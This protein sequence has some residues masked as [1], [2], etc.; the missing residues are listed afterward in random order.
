MEDF[1]EKLIENGFVFAG[2]PVVVILVFFVHEFA[3][4]MAARLTGMQVETVSVGVGK[5]YFEKTDRLGTRWVIRTFPLKAHVHISDYHPEKGESYLKRLTVVLAG[6]VSNFILPLLLFFTFFVFWGRPSVPTIVTGLEL[7]MPAYEAGI[8]I[9]DKILAIDN[10]PVSNMDEVKE[11][12]EL[13]PTKPLAFM[14]LREGQQLIFDVTPQWH[15]YRDLEGSLRAHGRTGFMARQLPNSLE[16]VKA[17]NGVEIESEDHARE[18]LIENLG[19]EVVLGLDSADREVHEYK[20]ILDQ[21]LNKGLFDPDDKDYDSFYAGNIGDNFYAELGLLGAARESYERSAELVYNILRLPFNLFPIDKEWISPGPKV[22]RESSPFGFVI[23]KL[24][25][26][27]SLFSVL[28]GWIN[29]VPFPGFDG[30]VIL[31]DSAE[32]I[33]KKKLTNRLKAILI[34]AALFTIYI[35]AFIA[36]MPNLPGYFEFKVEEF[37]EDRE[38]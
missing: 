6:P 27:G 10:K 36:N 32:A 1:I 18:L 37:L 38:D 20:I 23:F 12:T 19:K 9:G 24:I 30:Y 4:Y 29:L 33:A 2:L 22:S 28:I 14:V 11:I 31:I 3:H 8:K 21:D 17:V 13:K 34:V 16:M 7:R 15:E 25:F 35:S 26:L 5:K